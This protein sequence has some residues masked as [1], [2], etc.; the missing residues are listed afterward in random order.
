MSTG[1]D[2]DVLPHLDSA[3]RFALWLLAS[4]DDAGHAVEEA[5]RRA[6]ARART[7]SE[8]GAR[9]W[10][11]GIV[12]RACLER[13]G[14]V[15][16]DGARHRD[17]SSAAASIRRAIAGLPAH[18]REVIVLRDLEDLSYRELADVIG[19]SAATAASR[20]SCARRALHAALGGPGEAVLP[21][22]EELCEMCK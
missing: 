1:F 4:G 17:E 7:S 15:P 10:F 8:G 22:Q 5:A 3:Y 18:L 20:L 9:A 2:D 14:R 19:V 13:H 6:G 11:L 12:R 21:L 16:G